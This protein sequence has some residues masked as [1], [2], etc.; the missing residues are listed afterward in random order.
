M[1]HDRVADQHKSHLSQKV[2]H[3]AC[4]RANRPRFTQTEDQ[5][6]TTVKDHCKYSGGQPI[7]PNQKLWSQ[8]RDGWKAACGTLPGTLTLCS[9]TMDDFLLCRLV[10]VIDDLS[11][12]ALS[13]MFLTGQS[14]VDPADVNNIFSG[15]LAVAGDDERSTLQDTVGFLKNCT[16]AVN[17]DGWIERPRGTPSAVRSLSF[18]PRFF[19]KNS[20]MSFKFITQF[21][22][23]E[24]ACLW[25][26]FWSFFFLDCEAGTQHTSQ[27]FSSLLLLHCSIGSRR[28]SSFGLSRECVGNVQA[29]LETCTAF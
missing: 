18:H 6:L 26:F 27:I 4:W 29:L 7:D 11:N 23:K 20:C 28:E 14:E 12:V 3:L 24:L 1:F 25:T 17:S 10:K 16:T 19:L 15:N 21:G 13:G 22:C 2:P 9:T 5:D 8:D